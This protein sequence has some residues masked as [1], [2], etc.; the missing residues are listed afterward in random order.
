MNKISEISDIDQEIN[1]LIDTGPG[2]GQY[3]ISKGIN[4]VSKSP[5]GHIF[6]KADDSK[7]IEPILVSPGPGHYFIGNEKQQ[8]IYD[9]VFCYFGDKNLTDKFYYPDLLKQNSP[10]NDLKNEEVDVSRILKQKS[11][12]PNSGKLKNRDFM[13]IDKEKLKMKPGPGYYI[14]HAQN[15][16]K[17]TSG[18]K[19][20][21]AKE[22]HESYLRKEEGPGP[23]YYNTDIKLTNKG[24]KFTEEGLH[25]KRKA[26][27]QTPKQIN[28]GPLDYFPKKP[29]KQSP[30]ILF[31]K[32]SKELDSFLPK[33]DNPNI[34]NNNVKKIIV[35][36]ME[37][38]CVRDK[39]LGPAYYDPDFK[40]IQYKGKAI[41]FAKSQRNHKII[42]TPGPGQYNL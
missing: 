28:P 20:P 36:K 30:S 8:K 16:P 10:R 21:T 11:P 25:F 33:I 19:F 42:F 18:I 38:L 9:R 2:P 41:T 3:S 29:S 22:L 35:K 15:K 17:G 34:C 27:S 1:E 6:S 40:K 37:N 14:I 12:K 7:K 32:A 13:Y 4:L 24:I 39:L 23:G 5:S 26:R 31:G